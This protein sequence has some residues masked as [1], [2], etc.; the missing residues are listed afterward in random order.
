MGKQEEQGTGN[1]RP[2]YHRYKYQKCFIGHTYNAS[3]RTVIVEVCDEVLPLFGLRPWYAD[4]HFDPTTSLRDKVVEM[5]ANTRYGIYDLS[6]WRHNEQCRWEMPR[7][8]LI[9]LGMAIALNR[10]VLLLRHAENR[11]AGL[12]LPD[13]LQS[14]GSAFC[15]FTGGKKSL[16]DALNTHLPHWIK[17]APAQEWR[18]R[19]CLFGGMV[20]GHREAH[21]LSPHII[22]NNL[23]CHIA[24]GQETDQD[25][26]RVSVEEIIERF[27]TIGYHY[28]NSC[29]QPQGYNFSLCSHC[30]LVRSTPFAIYRLTAHTPAETFITI[31]MSIALE[32]QFGYKIPKI[33]L[34]DDLEHVPSLLT[35][36]EVVVARNDQE[37]R[38][39]LTQFLPQ[40]I[41]RVQETTWRPQALPFEVSLPPN[42]LHRLGR[43]GPTEDEI[44][45]SE[46]SG[47]TDLHDFSL[48]C[49]PDGQNWVSWICWAL[50]QAGHTVSATTVA[51]TAALR[52]ALTSADRQAKSI[53]LILSP[54][55]VGRLN[56]TEL[57][58]I[59]SVKNRLI[60]VQYRRLTAP[61]VR[62]DFA[63]KLNIINLASLD[64]QGA[65]TTLFSK[66]GDK[67]VQNNRSTVEELRRNISLPREVGDRKPH[68]PGKQAQNEKKEIKLFYCYAHEDKALRDQ[69]DLHL[70]A[71]RRAGH[72]TSW[73]D[74][75]IKSGTGWEREIDAHLNS[76]DIILLLVSPHF[77]ASDYCYSKEMVRAIERHKA[78]EAIVIPI[79][80]RP[81]PWEDAPFADLQLL[82]TGRRP[83][84]MWRDRN[85]AFMNV[86]KDIRAVI[87][88][89]LSK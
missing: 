32:T 4:A 78:K 37:L 24:D 8:V 5:I 36:Y 76:A 45:P 55:I 64:E 87:S 63:I 21:P 29:S 20:C 86:V 42:A 88:N 25:D 15:E 65:L 49:S 80:L 43:E 31:G 53:V 74:G 79:L 77:I 40:V 10:P 50:E 34:T 82:P 23:A 58:E 89:L 30:Q 56:I 59:Q 54:D 60:A 61:L 46:A 67:G 18:N 35:G 70:S 66:V 11:I 41:Q 44:Q 38:A 68:F 14:I 1:L 71:L 72:I 39:R 2:S 28:L 9:E 26:F 75:D 48:I 16:K 51:S 73:Y 52:E 13:C 19:Y 47:Q 6:Y 62:S 7:N 83:V 3:W 17:R 22:Q 69:L 27:D 85:A 57:P 12:A 84:T 33:L 81:I